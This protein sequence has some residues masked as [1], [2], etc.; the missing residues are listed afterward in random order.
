MN[1]SEQTFKAVLQT[2]RS[3]QLEIIVSWKGIDGCRCLFCSDWLG[4]ILGKVNQWVIA[5]NKKD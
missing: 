1:A 4:I 3:R 5:M 2:N